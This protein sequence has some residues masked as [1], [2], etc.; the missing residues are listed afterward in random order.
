MLS[1]NIMPF[2]L[3]ERLL[4]S[5]A[6]GATVVQCS[7]K[8]HAFG[9]LVFLYIIL[10]LS[11]TPAQNNL[12]RVLGVSVLYTSWNRLNVRHHIVIWPC[13]WRHVGTYAAYQ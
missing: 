11:S 1:L 7:D 3:Q 9:K 13:T 12:P 6:T 10:M 8:N 2:T 4:K 5:S